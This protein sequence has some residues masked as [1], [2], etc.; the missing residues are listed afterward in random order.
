MFL[1]YIVV[2]LLDMFLLYIVVPLLKIPV[3]YSVTLLSIVV[4]SGVVSMVTTH[5]RA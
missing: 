5:F 3:L 4:F 2:P 1:L